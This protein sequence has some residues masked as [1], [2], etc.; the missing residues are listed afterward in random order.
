MGSLPC[1]CNQRHKLLEQER[2]QDRMESV[3]QHLRSKSGDCKA[4]AIYA[5]VQSSM[6][7][8]RRVLGTEKGS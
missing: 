4:Q 1:T 7:Q 3:S 2:A 8:V 5:L 6:M